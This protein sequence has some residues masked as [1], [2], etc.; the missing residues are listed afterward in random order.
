MPA[1]TQEL[2][3][4]HLYQMPCCGHLLCW[5]N[6]RK[7]NFCPECGEGTLQRL[8]THAEFTIM[9]DDQAMLTLH[10]T[11]Q[12]VLPHDKEPA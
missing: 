4:F 8:R 1:K 6:P 2:V 10:T 11:L 3:D 12:V 5:V 7:P 9:H